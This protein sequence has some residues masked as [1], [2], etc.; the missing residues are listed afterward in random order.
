MK[1]LT[2]LAYT[3]AAM[4]TAVLVLSVPVKADNGMPSQVAYLQK[5]MDIQKAEIAKTQEYLK[6]QEARSKAEK[7]KISDIEMVK[8]NAMT[9]A[10]QGDALLLEYGNTVMP[11]GTIDPNGAGHI[12]TIDQAAYEGYVSGMALLEKIK[13]DTWMQ[14]TFRTH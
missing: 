7:R 9:G 8:R 1:V 12:A 3:L 11:Y 13:Q 5:Q 4:I 6:L 2:K 14:Y 10:A